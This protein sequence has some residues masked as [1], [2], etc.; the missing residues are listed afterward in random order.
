MLVLSFVA[1]QSASTS[2]PHFHSSSLDSA[3]VSLLLLVVTGAMLLW[4]NFHGDPH[5]M[6]AR[7]ELSALVNIEFSEGSGEKKDAMRAY[8][9]RLRFSMVTSNSNLWP[10]QRSA[11]VKG[12]VAS[13]SP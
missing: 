12:H 10:V 1:F 11:L 9:V 3:L 7:G 2:I 5:E 4:Y 8:I 13:A 6:E